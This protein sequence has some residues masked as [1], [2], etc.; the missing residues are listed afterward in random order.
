[1]KGLMHC[2]GV[3]TT[4]LKRGVILILKHFSVCI[5]M[6]IRSGTSCDHRCCSPAK[7]FSCSRP[8]GQLYS[9]QL[10]KT[11]ATWIRSSPY[12]RARRILIEV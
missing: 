10:T 9:K 1:M 6:L 12:S 3:G 5:S 8:L 11:K 7:G 2:L 4:A